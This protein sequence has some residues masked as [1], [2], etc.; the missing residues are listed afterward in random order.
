MR[1]PRAPRPEEF[2]ELARLLVRCFQH[3]IALESERRH[4]RRDLLRDA[5]I[6]A[7]GGRPVSHIRVAYNHL[8]IYGCRIKIA[9]IGGVCTDPEYRGRGIASRL[10]RNCIREAADAG[11]ALLLI[12][13]DRGLYRR[14]QAVPFCPTLVAQLGPRSIKRATDPLTVRP[15]RPE[16]WF[17]CASLYQAEP[18]RFQRSAD[19]FSRALSGQGR[20]QRVW[21]IELDAEAVAYLVFSR[22]WGKPREAPARVISEYAGSRAALVQALPLLFEAG[23]LQRIGFSFPAYDHELAYLLTRYALDLTPGAMEDHTIRLLDPARL[24]RSLRPYVTGRLPNAQARC[25][26]F[27]QHGDTCVLRLSSEKLAISLS[28][29]AALVLG[30]PGA[31][32]LPAPF[33]AAASALFPLPFPMSGLNYV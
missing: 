12:S 6:I 18:V 23:S 29:A 26:S 4:P 9:S 31:P 2:D 19:F 30:G 10:L 17:P 27:Q 1:K 5:R 13:G 33:R 7:V 14:A 22:I 32:K 21:M 24:M 3:P 11:A 20:H 28:Q 16:D 25:I 15:A 8:S